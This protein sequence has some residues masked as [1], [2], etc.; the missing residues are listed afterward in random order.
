MLNSKDGFFGK[1]DE[2]V[3]KDVSNIYGMTSSSAAS[4][5]SSPSSSASGSNST[6]ISGASGSAAPAEAARKTDEPVAAAAPSDEGK[7]NKLIVGPDIKLK[8]E[9]NDCDTIIVEGRVEATTDSRVLQIAESGAFAGTVGIDVAEIRGRFQGEL[10][11]RQK[12][13]IYSTGSV[14]GKIRYGK[15]VIEEGGEINGDVSSLAAAKSGSNTAPARGSD[16]AD[17][18]GADFWHEQEGKKAAAG[19]KAASA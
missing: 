2:K 4:T 1:R 5:S 7:G 10:T 18:K 17:A 6:S 11:A 8:G 13:V 19:G 9:I 3:R 16:T 12:L 14:T 15:I